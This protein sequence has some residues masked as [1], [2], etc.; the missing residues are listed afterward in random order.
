M[1]LDGQYECTGRAIA[2]P[3]ASAVAQVLAKC[4]SVAL[5]F[6]FD[7]QSAVR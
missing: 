3:L 7:G 1:F 6:L 5:K 2:I 4:E